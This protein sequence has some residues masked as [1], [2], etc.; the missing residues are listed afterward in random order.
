[1]P[2]FKGIKKRI[3]CLTGSEGGIN[4]SEMTRRRF[5]VS[6]SGTVVMKDIYGEPISSENDVYND[7]TIYGIVQKLNEFNDEDS[8]I[9]GRPS[10]KREI[11][12]FVTSTTTD[13][14]MNDLI[15]FPV[16][17]NKWF[18]VDNVEP[19]S[20]NFVLHIVGHHEQRSTR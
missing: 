14:L 12:D 8:N 7:I 19:L 15:E 18:R 17:S 4:T 2:C 5:G 9:G 13:V 1:M 11:L 20:G 6:S 16:A 10:T 3:N